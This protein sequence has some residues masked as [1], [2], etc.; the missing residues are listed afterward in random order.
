MDHSLDWSNLQISVSGVNLY[1]FVIHG[2][3][4]QS[5]LRCVTQIS[6][7]YSNCVSGTLGNCH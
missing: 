2:Q 1:N 6:V 3:L 5:R 7:H 4:K